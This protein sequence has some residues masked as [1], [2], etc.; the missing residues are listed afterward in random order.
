LEELNVLSPALLSS[1]YSGYISHKNS[2][3]SI[4][5]I[6]NR[7]SKANTSSTSHREFQRREEK[8]EN[9][10]PKNKIKHEGSMNNRA[11]LTP[12]QGPSILAC[13][14]VTSLSQL[15]H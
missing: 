5:R 10:G 13:M 15:S 3:I 14:I 12:V 8:T 9:R 2:E 7:Q 1:Q 6:Q 4:L 11:G